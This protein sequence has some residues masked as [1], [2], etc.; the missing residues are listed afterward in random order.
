MRVQ[1]W[2]TKHAQARMS[3]WRCVV[4]LP[5]ALS[6]GRRLDVRGPPG[7]LADGRHI[8]HAVHVIALNRFADRRRDRVDVQRRRRECASE[9]VE[10]RRHKATRNDVRG[11]RHRDAPA[12]VQAVQ[13]V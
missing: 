6:I 1:E 8:L 13:V 12:A 9:R 5:L 10:R 2:L 11:R 4:V 3:Q 7:E